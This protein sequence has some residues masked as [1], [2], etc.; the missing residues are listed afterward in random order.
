MRVATRAG[1]TV[2]FRPFLEELESRQLL[3]T[4]FT[5]TSGADDPGTAPPP[6]TTSTG[7][8]RDGILYANTYGG[9]GNPVTINFAIATGPQAVT[10]QAPLPTLTA[11]D[12]VLNGESQPGW[13]VTGPPV[14]TLQPA[15]GVRGNGLTLAPAASGCTVEGLD[16]R[17]FSASGLEVDS[18]NNAI[19]ADFLTQNT[20]GILLDAGASKNTVGGTTAAERNV[21]SGNTQNGVILS[22]SGTSENTIQGDFIGTDATGAAALANGSNGVLIQDGATDNTVGGPTSAARNVISGNTQSGVAITGAGTTGNVL[23]EDFIGTDVTGAFAVANHS[24]GVVLSAGASDNVLGGG[25]VIS[26]NVAAEVFIENPGTTGNVVQGDFIGT[27]AAGSY[28]IPGSTAPVNGNEGVLISDGATGTQV[29]GATAAARNII[30]GNGD[31]G[32]VIQDAGSN[33]NLVEGNYLGVDATGRYAIPNA[34]GNG[35]SITTGARNNMVGGTTPG[36]RNVISGN[37]ETS[38]PSGTGVIVQG[39]GTTGNVI[40]GNYIGTDA[41]GSYAIGNLAEGVNVTQGA[42]DNVVGGPTAA[43]RNVISGNGDNGVILVGAGTSDNVV[44]GNY[45]GTD[46]TGN[47]AIANA[48]QGVNVSLGAANNLVAGNLISANKQN[49]VLLTGSGTTGNVIAAN[50]IGTTAAGSEALGNGASGVDITDG[51]A[52]NTI[53]GTTAGAGNTI[54]NNSFQ[55]VFL[56][57]SAGMGNAI[58]GNS[59]HNNAELGIK[60]LPSFTPTPP[61]LTSVTTTTGS[62]TIDGTLS[63]PAGSYLVQFFDNP[64]GSNPQGQTLLGSAT[65]TVSGSGPAVFSLTL[66]VGPAHLVTATATDAGNNTSQFS[67][68]LV[69][70]LVPAPPPS[71]PPPSSPA[72][73]PVQEFVQ[74]V[75]DAFVLEVDKAELLID[76]FLGLD[77]LSVVA[78][79]WSAMAANPLFGTP[80]GN[81]AVFLGTSLALHGL[82][83]L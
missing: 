39:A 53:G 28:A 69:A 7:T 63:G 46:A 57:S 38:V 72:A 62:T 50:L 2:W 3:S 70:S 80:A 60:S 32:V 49:G 48:A 18:D 47:H 73:S 43:A 16:I 34:G 13:T 58:L 75:R 22:G 10:V 12:T 36:S 37:G 26:G 23:A 30:S 5:V 68:A 25:D 8:L 71:P 19:S 56:E 41:G 1:R 74:L 27:N 20:I 11:P 81:V 9:V 79:M 44:E 54:A 78:S 24:A 29:G 64:A 15:A 51:V 40:E 61:T 14:I 77:R 31:N 76:P 59:I 6:V 66:R 33:D 83:L 42:A 82:G 67:S 4:V 55:G 17:G 65:V 45:L 21:I 35:V 52:G